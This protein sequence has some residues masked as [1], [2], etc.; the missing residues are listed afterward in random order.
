MLPSPDADQQRL[1]SPF[2]YQ[3]NDAILHTDRGIMPSRRIAWAS[4]NYRVT[5]TGDDTRATTHYWM[6]AL[7]SVSKKRDYFVSLNSDDLV[8]P[9]HVIYRTT[10]EH[11][12][13]TASAVRRTGRTSDA[14]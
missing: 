5:G 14:Q 3:R 2:R 9:E 12:V 11:P 13:F 4:W 10:Y 8:D 6:N 1:L 7:Q